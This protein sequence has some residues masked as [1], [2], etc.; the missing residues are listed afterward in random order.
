MQLPETNV[1]HH[2]RFQDGMKELPDGCAQLIVC[3]P[4]Y[5]NIKGDFDFSLDWKEWLEMHEELASE[6]HRVLAENGT[7]FIWGHAKRIAY[8]QVIFDKLF[9]LE[10]SIVWEK[11]DAQTNRMAP[12]DRMFAP[13]T[14]RLLMYSKEGNSRAEC[15]N[16]RYKFETGKRRTEIMEPLV[17]YLIEEMERAGLTTADVN[18]ITGTS[19]ASRWF[20][21]TSQWN[22]PT[23][24]RY[25]Q[26]R[27][28][29]NEASAGK[30]LKKEYEYLKKEYEYLK[31]E[32]EELRRPF[33]NILKLTDVWRFSQESHI[34]K[35][36]DHETVKPEKLTRAMLLSTTRPGALVVVPFAG[37]GT[38]C[39]M[40]AREGRRFIG[41]EMDEKYVSIAR[42]RCRP[43]LEG[44]QMSIMD[45]LADG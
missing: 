12:T 9:K 6:C 18:R 24:E 35:N 39:A 15:A 22:L 1:I 45:A 7:L 20:A 19:M 36:F 33:D 31:K 27:Q 29:F 37:A 26:L 21:R 8:Q 42:A 14:E 5:F 10:N 3:D 38:E 44:R 4:P 25:E 16:L 17:S 41:F 34:T 30:Y 43:Y 11:V 28:A 32:Y 40:A 13:V 2:C 23:R